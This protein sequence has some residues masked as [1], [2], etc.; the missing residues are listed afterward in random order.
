M[1]QNPHKK[2][3][4]LDTIN[5]MQKTMLDEQIVSRWMVEVQARLEKTLK[6]SVTMTL[7]LKSDGY[8]VVKFTAQCGASGM[9]SGL[10][11]PDVVSHAVGSLLYFHKPHPPPVSLYQKEG[12]I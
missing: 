5:H 8:I 2:V 10:S 11:L 1:K 4:T 12:V 9:K 7:E 6:E 3:M